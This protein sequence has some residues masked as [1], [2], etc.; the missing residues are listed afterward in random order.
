MPPP[1]P[2]ARQNGRFL[3]DAPSGFA[4]YFSRRQPRIVTADVWEFFFHLV[5]EELEG[6]RR[7]EAN[8]YVGQAYDFF[9]AATVSRVPGANPLLYYY[10]FLN[11]AKMALVLR[12]IRLPVPVFHGIKEP[13]HNTEKKRLRFEGQLIRMDAV[14]ADHSRIFPEFV[15]LFGGAVSAPHEWNIRNLLGQIPSIHRT[16]TRVSEQHS[17]F[18]PIKATQILHDGNHVWVRFILDSLDKDVR[19]TLPKA[20][21]RRAFRRV[22][23]R[24]NPRPNHRGETWFETRP[25]VGR[26][27]AGIDKAMGQLA[28][29]VRTIGVR[30]LLTVSGEGY[31]CYFWTGEPREELALLPA[32]Y[33]VMFYLGSITRYRP[34]EFDTVIS[35]GHAWLVHE[36]LATQP[37]QFSYGLAS[38]LAGIDV[39]RPFATTH[40]T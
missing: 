2:Q 23:H 17:A 26:R 29:A 38:Y 28:A 33:A 36:Y 14:A 21:K 5:D 11:L 31:R 3:E 10:S 18:V 20:R 22:L 24:V 40:L 34:Y 7:R 13:K 19:E 12:G 39:V 32:V 4:A 8:A 16:F 6:A 9:E 37:M 27:G 35:G 1:F 25:V 30:S 15:R